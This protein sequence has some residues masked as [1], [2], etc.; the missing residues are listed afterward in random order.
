MDKID[1]MSDHQS[2]HSTEMISLTPK[3]NLTVV[4]EAAHKH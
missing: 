4:V 3:Q 2:S 1:K